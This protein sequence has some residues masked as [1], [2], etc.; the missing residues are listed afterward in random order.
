M[1]YL[2]QKL[3]ENNIVAKDMYKANRPEIA[4]NGGLIILLISL[5]SLS[6]I[7]LFYCSYILP[8]NYVIIMVVTLF[9]LFGILDDMVNIG[10][11]AKLILLY[12]CSYS[13]ISCATVT[14]VY[15]P[16]IGTVDLGIFYL[17]LILPLYVP[18]VANLVNM[19]SGFNG[20]APGLSLMVLITLIIKTM[21][22]AGVMDIL[23]IVC[24]TGSLAAYWL[25]EKYPAR[26][27]WGG[28]I[29]A[30]SVGAAIGATIVIEGFIFSGFV[31]LIPHVINFLLYVY[32]RLRPE[33]YPV[34]KFGKIR[35]DGTLEVPNPLT[36]KWVLPYYFPMT[37]RQ[38][39]N[40]M[41]A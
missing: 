31:M 30:L 19:H 9:A 29:G 2:I 3:K 33:K 41:Y 7:S 13:L 18:V 39:V 11:P 20:L 27:F 32:W 24:L 35:E 21:A 23:F 8:A 34:A 25:F 28:N 22:N 37:E 26:I 1:P 14:L 17:Q 12:Y 4:V 40:V 6:V 38:G 16:F 5:L 36:L 10:R 15:V